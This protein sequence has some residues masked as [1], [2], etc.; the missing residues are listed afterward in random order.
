MWLHLTGRTHHHAVD[1]NVFEGMTVQG[2]ADYTVSGG[3]VV[4]ENGELKTES[5]WGRI[6]TREPFGYAYKD[7]FEREHDKNPARKM[8]EREPYAGPVIV[9]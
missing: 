1:F 5:G 3:R 9:L 2:V 4:W 6:V 7:Q 8:V